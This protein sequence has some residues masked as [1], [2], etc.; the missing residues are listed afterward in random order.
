ML[1]NP[2][3]VAP[4]ALSAHAGSCTLSH[5]RVRAPLHR[6]SVGAAYPDKQM[7]GATILFLIAAILASFAMCT[8]LDAYLKCPCLSAKLP[9]CCWRPAG[10]S[11]LDKLKQPLS[12]ESTP[13]KR[14][15]K[16]HP[17]LA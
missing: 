17:P 13:L 9:Q 2:T 15:L 16:E 7:V 8:C 12:S 14:D 6:S 1:S 10:P 5:Q 3:R 11:P 4:S